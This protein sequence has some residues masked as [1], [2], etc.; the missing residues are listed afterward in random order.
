MKPVSVPAA[1]VIP[2]ITTPQGTIEISIY[3]SS[4]QKEFLSPPFAKVSPGRSEIK[5]LM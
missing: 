5:S 1:F 2:I 4:N 3:L